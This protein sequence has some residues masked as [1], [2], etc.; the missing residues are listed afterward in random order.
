MHD[1]DMVEVDDYV[2]DTLMRDLVGHDR[3]P[4]AFLV[5]LS[6][7][8]EAA[9]RDGGSVALSLREISERTGLSRRSVQD[10]LARLRRR[11]LIGVRR[12]TVTAVAEYTVMRPWRRQPRTGPPSREGGG[13]KDGTG[14]GVG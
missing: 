9:R 12:E 7:W 10:S 14:A 6:L 11:R 4:S 5:Y 13:R 3:Q 8:R 1:H 2:L